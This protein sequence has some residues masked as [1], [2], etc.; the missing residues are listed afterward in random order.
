MQFLFV[1]VVTKY[2]N[3]ATFLKHLLAM[4]ILGMVLSYN[5]AITCE[6][7]PSFLFLYFWTN[8][9]TST[10]YV[11]NHQPIYYRILKQT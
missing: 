6:H 5:L 3:F 2:L 4:F 11:F 8:F 7:V 10:H 9:I 1:T